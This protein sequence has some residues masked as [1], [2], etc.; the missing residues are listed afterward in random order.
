[1]TKYDNWI[2]HNP[3]DDEN[4]AFSDW[5]EDNE[6]DPEADETNARWEQM[7]EDYIEAEIA[8]E[9]DRRYSLRKEGEL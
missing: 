3:R 1:M 7:K 5:C 4:D 6:L 9:A 2:S 8:N